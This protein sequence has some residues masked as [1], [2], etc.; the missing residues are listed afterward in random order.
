MGV[1]DAFFHL[2]YRCAYRALRVHWRL[3]HPTTH[4]ALVAVWHAGKVLLVQTSYY[5]FRSLPGG[6]VK[7][8]ES[9]RAA[10]VRELY[11][12]IGLRV[13]L[14]SLRE[15]DDRVHGWAGKHDHVVIFELE[16]D[17]PPS[18]AI[19]GRE[20]VSAD[21]FSPQGALALPLFPPIRRVIEARLW[22]QSP[23]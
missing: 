6:S 10:A 8:H 17:S 22:T 12:E 20:V 4:G 15:V 16:L 2:G 1:I 11:E 9:A 13:G 7:R 23:P 3:F 5:P 14:Q 21:F 19:D 18:V